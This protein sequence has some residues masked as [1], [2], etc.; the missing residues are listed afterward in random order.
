MRLDGVGSACLLIRA[1]LHRQG[2][3]FPPYVVGHAI[4]SEGLAVVARRMGVQ[5]WGR[6]DIIVRHA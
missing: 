5:P 1:D 2:V 6:T 4:E 3:L